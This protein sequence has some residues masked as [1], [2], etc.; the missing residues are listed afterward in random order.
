MPRYRA[1]SLSHCF[2]ASA[3]LSHYR[4]TA[5]AHYL[6]ACL[7]YSASGKS[8]HKYLSYL[9][10]FSIWPCVT[11]GF[12]PIIRVLLMPFDCAKDGSTYTWDQSEDSS[13][14]QGDG[15]HRECYK[16]ELGTMATW[17][18]FVLPIFLLVIL[19]LAPTHGDLARLQHVES[20][21]CYGW[22]PNVLSVTFPLQ[23][24]PFLSR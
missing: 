22:I 19:R 15:T 21:L 11:I 24:E 16:G 5:L 7:F 20:S 14:V 1:A 3:S 9:I 6:T 17:S 18:G 13:F 2:T 23:N 12:I 4:T 10:R 8:C